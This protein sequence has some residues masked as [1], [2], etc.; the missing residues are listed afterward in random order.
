MKKIFILLILLTAAGHAADA[1]LVLVRQVAA[2]TGGSG[3]AGPLTI[4]Y[5]VGEPVVESLAAGGLLLTQGF[6]QPEIVPALPPGGTPLFDFLLYP[7]PAV[8]TVKVA[9]NLVTDASVVLLIVNTTGQL[10]YQ[11]VQY[12]GAGKILISTPVDRLAA[13]IYTVV[14]KVQG[15]V[16]TEKLIVQ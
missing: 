12:Y 5:T 1:Q 6:Q 13:G 3:H 16:Y 7:N 14:L 15:Q 9:F 2:S 8:T 11:N 4:D 10:M